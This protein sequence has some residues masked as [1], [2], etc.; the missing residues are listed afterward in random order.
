MVHQIL[1]SINGEVGVGYA[2][3]GNNWTNSGILESPYLFGE[4]TI[5]TTL[6]KI[7]LSADFYLSQQANWGGRRNHVRV[8]FDYNKWREDKLNSLNLDRLKNRKELDS[9][10]EIKSRLAQ[11]MAKQKMQ[12]IHNLQD[13][14]NDSENRIQDSTRLD[15][16]N[17]STIYDSLKT[18]FAEHKLEYNKLSN[19]VDSLALLKSQFQ[20]P[21]SIGDNLESELD[22][23]EQKYEEVNGRISELKN[24][25]T[26]MDSLR[27]DD[28]L[29]AYGQ[30]KRALP[31]IKHFQIGTQSPEIS[32]FTLSGARIAGLHSRLSWNKYFFEVA[33]GMLRPLYA[34]N[35][36]EQRNLISQSFG[37]TINA[38][39]GKLICTRLGVG[40]LD[41]TYI[42]VIVLAE[43]NNN[44]QYDD[45]NKIITHNIELETG[46]VIKGVKLKAKAAQSLRSTSLNAEQNTPVTTSGLA[47]NA[48]YVSVQNDFKKMALQSTVALE[49]IGPNYRSAG[50]P[51]LRSDLIQ[52]NAK[53]SLAK[54][55]RL[56]PSVTYN[57]QRNNVLNWYNY[58]T[59]IHSLGADLTTKLSK[60]WNVRMGY[61]PSLIEQR[62]DSLFTMSSNQMFNGSLS[63]TNTW[64]EATLQIIGNAARSLSL[65]Q[66]AV[67]E[68]TQY[69]F[70]CL[71]NRSQWR[72]SG[73]LTYSNLTMPN[74]SSFE[75]LSSYLN[76]TKVFGES[77]SLSLSSQAL[78][79]FAYSNLGGSIELQ[80]K[81]RQ[82]IAITCSIEKYPQLTGIDWPTPIQLTPYGAMCKLTYTLS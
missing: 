58:Q 51:F 18:D 54:F 36:E 61:S 52:T 79:G 15:K 43:A 46:L 41:N 64:K 66:N 29:L 49:W 11:E 68:N 8:K 10:E 2:Y 53:L 73:M 34:R 39:N 25:L 62:Q 63:Y 24:K 77:W 44:S 6:L 72:V 14:I 5:Q 55:Q 20:T 13:Q 26:M 75:F 60:K 38:S 37:A 57:N 4:G 47:S 70:M 45:K 69:S 3:G 16:I 9:L 82:H 35:L 40:S 23:L 67:S 22:N 28:N 1:N 65:I 59:N 42:G 27:K 71:F 21:N 17:N 78:N 12:V 19:S 7:P 81:L 80:G 56:L 32:K 50:S 30:T 33:A 48:Y 74:S 76:C 31:R